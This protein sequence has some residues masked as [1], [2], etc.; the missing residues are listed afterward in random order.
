M[1][2]LL[3]L[4]LLSLFFVLPVTAETLSS[5]FNHLPSKTDRAKM[6]AL[7]GITNYTGTAAQNTA[8]LDCLKRQDAILGKNLPQ[9]V[10]TKVKEGLL[11]STY[12]PVTGY[13]SRTTQYISASATVIPVASTKDK[14]GN[15]IVLSN[16]SSSGTVK[17]YMN[18]E[19][20]TSNEEPIICTGVTASSW[21]GCTRGIPF[22]GGSETSSSTIAK[23]HNAGASI[24][25]TNIGQFFNQYVSIDGA[26]TI[27]DVKTFTSS[28]LIPNPA[29]G[30]GFAAVNENYVQ[31]IVLQ[32]AA[33][34]T[35]NNLGLVQLPTAL[36]VASSTASSTAGAPLVLPA[37]LS[38]STCSVAQKGNIPVSDN[39]GKVNPICLDRD[40]NWKFN[41]GVNVSTTPAIKFIADQITISSSTITSTI[42]NLAVNNIGSTTANATTTVNANGLTINGNL[43]V[44][45]KSF[46]NIQRCTTGATSTIANSNGTYTFSHSLGEIPVSFEFAASQ[47][48]STA[49]STQGFA[50]SAS[51]QVV[52]T[53][54][55]AGAANNQFLTGKIYSFSDGTDGQS[56][57]LTNITD[58]SFGLMVVKTGS[59]KAMNIIYKL[60]K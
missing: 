43:Q 8:L 29:A 53:A 48:A 14:A 18:L 54:G 33:T 41:G 34:S 10:P 5:Y 46:G 20:G 58:A 38:T 25:I 27:N 35:E 42:P 1:K 9:V 2:K 39:N 44:L 57:A 45:G 28:P 12:V 11:G 15:Q 6:A 55:N 7:C 56:G 16:I 51:D 21:T 32:G 30:N 59:G 60:C 23:P 37:R 52:L 17:V 31:S 49:R 22:Q 26:Q 47:D 19:A 50:S 36:Q 3:L 24:I 13:Q 4:S 40:V